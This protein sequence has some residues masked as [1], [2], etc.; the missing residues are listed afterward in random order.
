MRFERTGWLLRR[1][2]SNASE[3]HSPENGQNCHGSVTDHG[4]SRDG[5]SPQS[6]QLWFV[7]VPS[8][9]GISRRSAISVSGA[10][11]VVALRL[12]AARLKV[13]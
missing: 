9:L 2:A 13:W 3:N 4:K 12:L 8:Q 1:A 7:E 11:I 5:L 6:Q 10:D